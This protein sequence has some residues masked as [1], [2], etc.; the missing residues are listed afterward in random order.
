MSKSDS[1]TFWID[2]I[3]AEAEDLS[4]CF[5]DNS[6]RFVELPYSNV[7]LRES[8]LLE[9]FF[10]DGGRGDWEVDGICNALE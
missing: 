3:N 5:D 1:T 2:I 8:R 9:Q 4:V 10:Y 7:G 6:K